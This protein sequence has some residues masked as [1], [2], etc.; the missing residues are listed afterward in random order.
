[1][2]RGGEGIQESGLIKVVVE[3]SVKCDVLECEESP[4]EALVAFRMIYSHC[5]QTALHF[6]TLVDLDLIDL[7]RCSWSS[8]HSSSSYSSASESGRSRRGAAA[9][10]AARRRRPPPEDEGEPRRRG[11]QRPGTRPPRLA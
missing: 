11:H 9:P 1:M 5:L 3:H 2:G 8:S 7:C 10:A 4:W 6:V